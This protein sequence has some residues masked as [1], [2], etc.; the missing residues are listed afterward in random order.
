MNINNDTDSKYPVDPERKSNIYQLYR[1]WLKPTVVG[2]IWVSH[3]VYNK[4]IRRRNISFLQAC[5]LQIWR[6]SIANENTR[7]IIIARWTIAIMIIRLRFGFS[8]FISFREED[9]WNFSQSEHII[10]PGS[11]IEYPTGTK[12]SNF[13]SPDPKGHVRYCHCPSS[14]R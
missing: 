3:I 12:N 10:G 2:N 8:Q 5:Q 4:C 11:H 14:I 6:L 9:L 1:S 7:Y 13:S